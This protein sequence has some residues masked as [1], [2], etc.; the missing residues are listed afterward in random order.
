MSSFSIRLF[1][2]LENDEILRVS[3]AKFERLLQGSS[4]EK[5]GRFAGKRVRAAEIVVGL[6]NRK[7]V[8]VVRA[9]YY[10]LHFKEKGILDYDR[11]MKNGSIVADAGSI[12]FYEGVDKG[13]IINA[14]K[15]FALR[16][17]DH[18]VWWEPNMKLERDILDASIDEF[19][20]KRL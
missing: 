7:P 13:N 11:F 8:M 17:R 6:E 18:T 4:Q 3:N 15:R 10:Y 14:Q 16:R 20:C 12:D 9:L 1:F 5:T 2:I 19:K